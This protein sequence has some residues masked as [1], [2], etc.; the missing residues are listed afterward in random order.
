MY[1]K[2]QVFRML[3]YNESKYVFVTKAVQLYQKLKG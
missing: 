3:L 2:N 1:K